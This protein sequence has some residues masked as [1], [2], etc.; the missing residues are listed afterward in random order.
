MSKIA[1]KGVVIGLIMILF[2]LVACQPSAKIETT[3]P[4]TVTETT[5][6]GCTAHWEC[7]EEDY[8]HFQAENCSWSRPEKCERGCVNSTCRPAEV[9]TTG[10]KCIDDF[11][12]GYQKEDCS[13]LSKIACEW[14]C[15]AGKCQEKPTNIFT[16]ATAPKESDTP[17]Y[18]AI[19][20]NQDEE[21]EEEKTIYTLKIGEQQQIQV[22]GLPTNVS[23]HFLEATQV[24]LKVNGIKSNPIPEQG[25]TTY[26]NLGAT[27]KVEWILFQS[28]DGGKQEIGYS[29]K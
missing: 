17:K 18:S 24:T 19:A 16:N 8:Q 12:R 23:I 13:F 11:R 9:C 5:T 4:E 28:Y 21:V 27:F 3:A 1:K 26:E 2:L 20:E 25:N 15:D 22:N 14:G 10:F 7:A 29:V 6:S